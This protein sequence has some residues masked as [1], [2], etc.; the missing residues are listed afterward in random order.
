MCS[1]RTELERFSSQKS[2]VLRIKQSRVKD[3]NIKKNTCELGVDIICIHEKESRK[4]GLYSG[5]PLMIW[6]LADSSH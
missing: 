5:M 6:D 4:G 3:R 2:G 1:L